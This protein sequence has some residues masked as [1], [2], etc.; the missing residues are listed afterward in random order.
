MR[1]SFKKIKSSENL[2]NLNQYI[3]FLDEIWF[4]TYDI[5]QKR[6]TDDSCNCVLKVP[7]CHGKHIILHAVGINGWVSNGLL[8]SAKNVKKFNADYNN[9]M[10]FPNIPPKTIIVLDSV[11]SHLR[12]KIPNMSKH[13]SSN[14]KNKKMSFSTCC[15]QK[16]K[17]MQWMKW[18]S[19][20][21][22]ILRLPPYFCLFNHIELIYEE[23]KRNIRKHTINLKVPW[24]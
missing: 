18:T 13:N 21:C 10:L 17:L 20:E 7:T 8:I 2:R 22:E 19:H 11:P 16:Q 1:F 15:R 6:F 23:L 14:A 24:P 3:I 5:K 4:N 9:Y 12:Q